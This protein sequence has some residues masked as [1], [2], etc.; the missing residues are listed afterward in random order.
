MIEQTQISL[1]T[2]GE[3]GCSER[4]SRSCSISDIRRVTLVTNPLICHE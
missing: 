2:G 3:L 1:K 4:L